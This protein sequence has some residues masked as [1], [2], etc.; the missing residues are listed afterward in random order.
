MFLICFL[1]FVCNKLHKTQPTD[2]KYFITNLTEKGKKQKE[3]FTELIRA[4]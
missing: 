4:D 1:L 2:I 3:K